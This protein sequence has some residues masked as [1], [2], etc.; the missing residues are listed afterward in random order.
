M[1]SDFSIE[2]TVIIAVVPVAI[3]TWSKAQVYG[4]LPAAIVGLNPTR[5][6]D[7]CLL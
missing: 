2:I 5:G 1:N 3:D 7:L 6:M 4:R